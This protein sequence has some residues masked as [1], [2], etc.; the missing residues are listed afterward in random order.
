M[1]EEL[2]LTVFVATALLLAFFLYKQEILFGRMIKQNTEFLKLAEEHQAEIIEQATKIL[3]GADQRLDRANTMVLENTQT[4]KTLAH[5]ADKLAVVINDQ[6]DF[7]YALQKEY[8]DYKRDKDKTIEDWHTS[9]IKLLHK[10]EE[11]QKEKD[12]HNN[13]KDSLI[14]ELARRAP[15][16][17][18]NYNAESP[19]I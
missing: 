1:I 15:M 11:L 9:Y 2:D 4:A 16:T 12:E 14:A 13:K 18:N 10:Y 6:K 5:S 3:N 19:T 17:T 7:I 8:L